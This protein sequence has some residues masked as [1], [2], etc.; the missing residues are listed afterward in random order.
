MSKK[1]LFLISFVLVV[2]LASSSY[3][4]AIVV[5]NWENIMDGWAKDPCA[6]AGT[7][8]SYSATGVT[9]DTKSLK[10]SVPEPNWQRA[11][12]LRLQ[13]KGLVDDFFN[14]D[15]FSVDVTRLPGEWT[16]PGG[17]SG[18]DL[19]VSANSVSGP[20]FQALGG[21]IWWSP[22][23]GNNPQTA[24]W[25]YSAIKALIDPCSVSYLELIIATNYDADFTAGGKYYLDNALLA[26]PAPVPPQIGDWELRRDGWA[27]WPGPNPPPVGTTIDY[28]DT[29][30]V[31]LHGN[32]LRLKVPDGGV[33]RVLY[34]QLHKQGLVDDFFSNS[35]FSVDVTRL[36]N[37]WT[38]GAAGAFSG[39]EL[40][41]NASSDAGAVFQNLGGRVWWS[42]G[43]GNG[44][45][46]ALWDY[47]ATKSQIDPCSVSYLEFIIVTNFDDVNY[48]EGTYYLD[49]AKLIPRTGYTVIGDW[50][51]AGDGWIEWTDP[52]PPIGPP[53]Y[54]YVTTGATLNSKAV[55]VIPD[56][57]YDQG[58]AIKLQNNGL[59][60]EGLA[61]NKFSIDVTLVRDEWKGNGGACGVE[62]V[63]NEQ[64]VGWVG[65]GP[66]D[67]DTNNPATPGRWDPDTEPNGTVHTTRMVW[68]YSS[69]VPRMAPPG[70]FEFILVT[71]Y[72][73]AY[74]ED[75]NH[76]G[77]FYFDNARLTDGPKASDPTPANGAT[78]VENKPTLSWRIGRY[79]DTH[80]V[81][82][83]TDEAKVTDANRTSHPDVNYNNVSDNSYVPGN[84]EFKTTYYWRVDEVN[85]AD[86]PNMWKGDV[87][88]FTVGDYAIVEN[89]NSYAD[90]TALQNVW[91]G[92]G[93]AQISL[94]LGENDANLVRDGNSMNFT[95][96][97]YYAFYSEAYANTASLPSGIGSNWTAVGVK[98]LDLYFYGQADNDA[99]E[100]M[101][102][103][104]TDGD[105]TPHSKTVMYDGD[106]N[107]IKKAEWQ[108]WHIPLSAFTGVNPANVKKIAI[109]FGDG[110]D[111]GYSWGNSTVYFEDIRLYLGGR[112]ILSKRSAD[113]AKVDYAPL[114]SGGDCVID[115]QEL[116]L[117]V[118]D[119]LVEDGGYI[120]TKNPGTNGL[121]AYYPL[122]EGSGTTT[123]DASVND[124]NG[125]F[126]GGVSWVSPGFMG[127]SNINVNGTA[128]SKVSIGT[129][130]PAAPDGKLTLALWI[131]WG[132]PYEAGQP[133]GLIAKREDWSGSRMM[134]EFECDTPDTP[135][136]RG[137][138]AL[139]S[140]SRGVFSPT[141]ILTPLI[142][143][144]AHVASTF[145]G[146]T[147]RLYLNS[148]EVASGAFSFSSMTTAM[149]C[150]ANNQEGQ[151][152]GPGVFKGD[153]D[154]VRIF[155]RALEPNEIAYLADT[156]PGD[157]EIYTP[158]TSIA[159]L[160]S[161]EPKGS[162]IV[163]FKD[164]AVLAKIW[165]EEDLFP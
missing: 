98:A 53:K 78:D 54:T 18:V 113:F 86:D 71:T 128:L 62:L 44:P 102:V 61:N 52:Q 3:G 4:Q 88:S 26:P 159:E 66:P 41:V 138:F 143:Q 155:N 111:P 90:D 7:T 162:R 22:G 46:K 165:L 136:Y 116:E 50:E 97:N 63:L 47:S 65:L 161:G 148:A 59:F 58:L 40:I 119:W 137:T 105:G 125:T 23:D 45:K 124:H 135:A 144:W 17:Y 33:Q 35:S 147:A 87:W 99:N 121:V 81:Y 153:M 140:F 76:P 82:F 2:T 16:G 101:Y 69:Y 21:K 79:A 57:A 150:L 5:G 108:V 151:Y 84:L 55:K 10:L 123:D 110:I 48:T 39:V 51:N 104:L 12:Y 158:L 139:R 103:K 142:G 60:A 131:K 163:N 107:D 64:G 91:K 164:F 146:T 74:D 36:A 13:D 43:D 127:A 134:F 112:C 126:V 38:P 93:G 157:G 32:S 49:N 156:T 132:G 70:W 14:N 160:Y 8:T 77:N 92:G 20:V 42:P 96:D 68:D 56:G 11:I 34:I 94:Q 133:Q 72:D 145:D 37:E 141:G 27:I 120:A 15:T 9:L 149:M 100:Q 28:N 19:V 25:D 115:Y 73:T 67:I 24:T 95:F 117:M 114:G 29:T 83:G 1:I 152:W 130:N 122:N 6:P 89:F 129:W 154:E 31:T 80:D 30:G 106:K 118:G 75:G 109:G 85:M